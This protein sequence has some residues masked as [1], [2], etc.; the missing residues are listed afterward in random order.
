MFNYQY[1]NDYVK[2]RHEELIK[3]AE[4]ERLIRKNRVKPQRLFNGI[5]FILNNLKEM[6]LNWDSPVQKKHE[7]APCS[8]CCGEN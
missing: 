4:I 6:M 8:Q 2:A 7:V 3:E 1:L 5:R